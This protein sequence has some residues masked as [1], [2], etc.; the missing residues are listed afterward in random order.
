MTSVHQA[1]G[2]VTVCAIIHNYCEALL[3][4]LSVPQLALI[5][6]SQITRKI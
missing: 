1:Q 6:I 3:L 5:Q 4:D 2:T